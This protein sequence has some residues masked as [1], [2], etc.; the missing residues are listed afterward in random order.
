ME[1][2]IDPFIAKERLLIWCQ[3]MNSEIVFMNPRRNSLIMGVHKSTETYGLWVATSMYNKPTGPFRFS[4][5]LSEFPKLIHY[6]IPTP[7]TSRDNE[8]LNPTPWLLGQDLS[9]IEEFFDMQL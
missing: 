9:L 2:E 8:P 3:K 6:K 1:Y 5:G 4:Q 7:E